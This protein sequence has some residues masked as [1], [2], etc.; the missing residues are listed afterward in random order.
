MK[1]LATIAATLLTIF[2]SSSAQA[3]L[4]VASGACPGVMSFEVFGATPFARILYLYAFDT[5]SFPLPGYA[6]CAG[7]VTGLDTTATFAAFET[8]NGAG[9]AVISRF[10]PLAACGN[11]YVQ[12]ID[13][14]PCIP[15]NVI[16]IP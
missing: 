3:Q 13:L 12:A 14:N 10:V 16:L 15:S 8:A 5:G 11:V 6:P 9:Y 2:L 1:Y 7:L 4:L